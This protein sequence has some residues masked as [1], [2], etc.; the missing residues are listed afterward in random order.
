[1]KY[2]QLIA[3]GTFDLFHK[4]HKS[5]L[6]KSFEYASYV[7]VCITSN[8][9]VKSFKNSKD[10]EDFEIRK[11]TVSDFLTS[12]GVAD[13]AK[14][15]SIDDVFGPL[16]TREFAPDAIAVTPTNEKNAI[17]INEGRKK[18][19][20][21]DLK[22]VV[23]PLDNSEDGIEISSTRIR[24]GEINR[25]GRLYIRNDWRGK[26]LKLPFSLRPQLQKPLGKV[27]GSVPSGLDPRKIITIGDISTQ[28][29]NKKSVGQFLSIVDFKVHREK[30]FDRL[31]DLG[32]SHDFETI[33]TDNP[34]GSIIPEL[35]D[36]V[37]KAFRTS[38]RKIILVNGEE[39]L[40]VLPALLISPL[41]FTIYYGQPGEG[42]VEIP[43]TEQNK[44]K[45]YEL[46][47]KFTS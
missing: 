4:G 11:K 6:K 32:F 14:I 13:R 46:V 12:I 31:S 9:Y 26:T 17:K 44:E 25:E 3:S 18:I 5:F 2:R 10:I 40:A 24:N 38:D 47:S 39:D 41:R 23:I 21:P 7:I 29:F 36:S 19:G 27:L 35:F 16:L 1:M 30:K 33:E 42:L 37:R 45:A 8:D 15:I 34:A 43:V 22:I 20:L 28:E